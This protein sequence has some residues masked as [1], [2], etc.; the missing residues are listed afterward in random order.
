[1]AEI[2]TPGVAPMAVSDEPIRTIQDVRRF[3]QARPLAERLPGPSIHDVFVHQ[4]AV[5]PDRTAVT[6]LTTGADDENP[7]RVSY[8]ELLGLVNR[9]ANAF[10]ALAGPRPGVAYLLPNLVHTHLTLWGG[11]TAG[12]A[13][14]I[15]ILLRP[16]NVAGLVRSSGARI[17]VTLGPHP[18]L[19]V[20]ATALAVRDQVPGLILMVV[21]AAP[22]EFAHASDIVS[23]DAA[24]AEQPAD[25]LVFGPPG[26]GDDLAAYLHTGGTTGRPKLVRLTHAGQ[27]AAALGGTVLGDMH[28]DDVLT[29][30]LPLFHAGGTIFCSLSMF[31]A[32]GELLTMSPAGLRNPAMV[33]GFW[34][35]SARYGATLVGAVPTGLA[36]VTE[37]PVGQADLS[38]VRAGFTG[39]SSI[40]ASVGRRFRELTGRRLCEVYGM[41]EASGVIS[42]DPVAGPGAPGSVG[43]RLPYTEVVVR[44]LSSPAG[45]DTDLQG[46]AGLGQECG[47]GEIGAVTVRGPNVSPGYQDSAHDAGTFEDGWLI[48]GDLGYRDDGGNLFI[49]GRVKDLIV[50]SGHNIDPLMIENALTAHPTVALAA[51]VG[52]PDAYAGEVPVCYVSLLP[53]TTATEEELAEHARSHIGERPAWP[54]RIL[55]V[56]DIPMTAVGKIFKP[57]LRQ[58][59]AERL[60]TA[61]VTEQLGEPPTAVRASQGGPRGLHVDVVL[62]H[63]SANRRGDVEQL[64]NAYLFEATVDI[65]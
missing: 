64:L 45:E 50:R 52:M 15:N 30:S 10:R 33:Q 6:M 46:P 49:A 62:P 57:Q 47:P 43:I 2:T 17:L 32:G 53:G 28:A 18:T 4:A 41:T 8:G 14:P 54:R 20:W 26:A 11:A 60:V 13:V 19:D 58:D 12:Y 7:V 38:A 29:A 51:A 44:R 35:L 21:G 9:A 34:R 22:D 55:V 25:R 37:V 31:L 39:A 5:R 59:A 27:L 16:D 42:I 61:V 56:D 1:M 48:T 3:E 23:F 65:R 63:A 24:L 40:P 36:A